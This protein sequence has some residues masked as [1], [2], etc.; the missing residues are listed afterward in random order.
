M[1]INLHFRVANLNVSTVD[2]KILKQL[3]EKVNS[4]NSKIDIMGQN[5]DQALADLQAINDKLQKIGTESSATLQKVKELEEAA[6][7]NADTPQAVL[8]KIAE[9]KAQ[10]QIVDDLV[11]DA[12]EPTPEP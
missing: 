10:A 9:V 8:D 1:D 4:L 5:T 6:A 2:E 11:P 12:T 3:V 7:N